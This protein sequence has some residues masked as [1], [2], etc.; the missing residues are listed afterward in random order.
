MKFDSPK[1]VDEEPGTW[2]VEKEMQ[3]SDPGHSS[4][5]TV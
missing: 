5:S 1:D 2:E 3:F 4:T